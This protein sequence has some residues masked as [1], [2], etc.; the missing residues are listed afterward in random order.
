MSTGRWE[1]ERQRAAERGLVS[2]SGAAQM[3]GVANDMVKRWLS[4]GLIHDHGAGGKGHPSF[5]DP[6]EVKTAPSRRKNL[7][8]RGGCSE[9]D[10]QE[11]HWAKGLC[12]RHY[13]AKGRA[14]G[15]IRSKPSTPRANAEQTLRKGHP[16]QPMV[17]SPYRLLARSCPSCGDLLTTPPE[18]IRKDSGPL[19]RCQGCH[20]NAVMRNNRQRQ[21]VTQDRAG[22]LGKQW[23]GPEMELVLRRDLSVLEV[24]LALGRTIYGVRYIRRQL[25][26]RQD[27]RYTK[28][29]G[30]TDA[31]TRRD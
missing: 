8:A 6:D 10:C 27:P 14:E 1:I 29:A 26:E 9:A 20:V 4:L 24:A 15:R 30:V 19:P 3:M 22:N 16:P 25:I 23:T 21:A 13:A 5:F 18:L 7:R 31:M 11:L 12:A 17:S 28:V 2:T